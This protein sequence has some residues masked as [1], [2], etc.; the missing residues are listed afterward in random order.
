MTAISF[1]NLLIKLIQWHYPTQ[2]IDLHRYYLEHKHELLSDLDPYLIA[3]YPAHLTL[4]SLL[5]T[6]TAQVVQTNVSIYYRNLGCEQFSAAIP[7]AQFWQESRLFYQGGGTTCQLVGHP[8]LYFSSDIIPALVRGMAV[9]PKTVANHM[10][11]KLEHVRDQLADDAVQPARLGIKQLRQH[12]R[13]LYPDSSNYEGYIIARLLKN[14]QP[15]TD[16]TI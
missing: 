2:L 1:Y 12:I 13:A 3:K 11:E 6:I 4:L 15:P 5:T 9:I 7:P 8:S 14:D 10:L 16:T